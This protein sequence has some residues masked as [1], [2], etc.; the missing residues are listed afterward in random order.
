MVSSIIKHLKSL[1][2]KIEKCFPTVSTENYKWLRNPFLPMDILC[3][4]NLKEEEELID[5]RND[6]NIKLLHREM[7]LDEFWIKIQNEYHNIGEKALVIL[8]QFS[9]TILCKTAFPVLT[10]LKTRKRERL[11][12]VEEEMRVALSNVRPNIERICAKNQA[13]ISH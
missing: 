3:I 4:L 6:G 13:Q 11:L 5:I 2:D 7:P 8:L 9:T 12:V 10:N 1:L